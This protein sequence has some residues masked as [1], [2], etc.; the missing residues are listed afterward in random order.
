MCIR[1]RRKLTF[2]AVIAGI[3][4]AIRNSIA[5]K[6]GSYTPQATPDRATAPAEPAA[7]TAEPAAETAPVSSG[8]VPHAKDFVDSGATVE[9]TTATELDEESDRMP[10][11]GRRK[12]HGLAR[13][14]EIA[15][16]KIDP[17]G[18]R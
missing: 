11:R 17:F 16:T 12:G 14:E 7:E 1:D 5:D 9:A 13:D 6:G 4:I 8:G 2:I 3:V 15:E 10:P 18:I